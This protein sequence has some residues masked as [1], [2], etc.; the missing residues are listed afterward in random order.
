MVWM[1]LTSLNDQ[2]EGQIK[3][4]EVGEKCNARRG[5]EKCTHSFSREIKKGTNDLEDRTVDERVIIKWT[6]NLIRKERQVR[7]YK[8]M[9]I[10]VL[11]YS[12]ETRTLTKSRSE[13]QKQQ[14]RNF[15]RM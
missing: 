1:L 12:P 6:L 11:T 8:V 2:L 14:K 9:A 5:R 3:E 4:A 10:P 15:T 7:F 13:R